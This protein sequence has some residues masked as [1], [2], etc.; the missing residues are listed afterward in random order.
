LPPLEIL[1]GAATSFGGSSLR[2]RAKDAS[3][4][5]ICEM[6]FNSDDAEI[7]P[8]NF[9]GASCCTRL[10]GWEADVAIISSGGRLTND[11]AG[12]TFAKTKKTLSLNHK[13]PLPGEGADAA[14]NTRGISR[15]EGEGP[16]SAFRFARPALLRFVK[17]HGRFPRVYLPPNV[18]FFSI[19][20]PSEHPNTF[21]R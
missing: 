1:Y 13:E 20:F 7:S 9:F 12:A 5:F 3:L 16:R 15:G 19:P 11:Y 21:A 4:L 14:Y 18:P 8:W 2:A 6:T 17:F 10:E